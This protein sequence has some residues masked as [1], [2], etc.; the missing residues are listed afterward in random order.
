[1]LTGKGYFFFVDRVNE[2]NPQLYKDQNLKCTAS[3]LCTEITLH[4]DEFHTYA[5]VLS[6]MNLSMYDEWKDTDAVQNAIIFLDC[7]AEE[8]IQMG[9]GIKG[10][11]KA[12]RFT[13]KS[14]ALGLGALGYHTY[15]QSKL[16]PFESFEAH[17]INK[18]MFSNIKKEATKS[19]KYLAR[20]KGEPEWCKGYGVRNTHLLAIAPNTSSALVCGS[21]SQGIEPVYKN[22]FVQGSAGGEINRIN[23]ELI[24]LLR[25]KEVY[26]DDIINDIITDGGSV[27]V[28]EA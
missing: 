4:S 26:N 14:R 24:K 11:E 22:A 7:V 21:V 28:V 17:Q 5:C 3:Q 19:T 10:L 20:L 1:M 13:E 9:R 15:L 25:A 27:R 18:E 23:P 8:F 2:Q 12:V 6:S 16:I